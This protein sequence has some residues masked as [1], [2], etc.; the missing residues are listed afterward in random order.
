MTNKR[1]KNVE[2]E[3]GLVFHNN[4]PMQSSTV[5][6]D[7]S[8]LFVIVPSLQIESSRNMC[9]LRLLSIVNHMF[10][11][12][13]FFT[14]MF[15]IISLELWAPN[16]EENKETKMFSIIQTNAEA[17]EMEMKTKLRNPREFYVN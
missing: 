13:M 5:F 15:T 6:M 17:M 8:R 10:P 3:N 11:A 4:F 7:M 16:T 2:H 12:H 9:S 14:Y 1:G